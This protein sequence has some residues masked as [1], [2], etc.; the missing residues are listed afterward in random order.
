MQVT[1]A[2]NHPIEDASQDQSGATGVANQWG[3]NQ[4][5]ESQGYTLSL[6]R[7]R[8][9]QSFGSIGSSD[10]ADAVLQNAISQIQGLSGAALAAHASL[11]A[12]RALALNA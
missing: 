8:S 11:S 2:N 3:A 4:P 9:G 12:G 5:P 7:S 6:S 10:A 1:G